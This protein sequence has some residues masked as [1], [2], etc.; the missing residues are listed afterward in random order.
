MQA[1]ELSQLMVDKKASDLH[2]EV[3][4]PPLVRVDGS[5]TAVA[6]MAPL[7]AE[8][9]EAIFAE[10]TTAEQRS[11]FYEELEL[12]FAYSVPGLARFR[13]NVLKQR[14]AIGIVFR[15]P[16]GRHTPDKCSLIQIML[17]HSYYVT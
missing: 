9:I 3:F 10:L 2:L 13:V 16:A 14:G 11:T 7:S 4:S 6:E 15:P 17:P 5:L 1:K 8:D 12:G